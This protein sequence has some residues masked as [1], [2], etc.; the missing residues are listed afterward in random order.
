MFLI[1]INV[2]PLLIVDDCYF[3][4][5]LLKYKSQLFQNVTKTGHFSKIAETAQ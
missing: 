2:S 5:Y 3:L 4:A 1:H